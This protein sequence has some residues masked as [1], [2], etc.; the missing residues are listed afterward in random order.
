MS[1]R[2]K[3]PFGNEFLPIRGIEAVDIDGY[4]AGAIRYR[5][6]NLALVGPRMARALEYQAR[7]IRF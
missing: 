7:D 1:G 4:E 2:V 5:R 3:A 6:D